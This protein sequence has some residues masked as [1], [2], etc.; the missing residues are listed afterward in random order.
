MGKYT[1][2][3]W[4]QFLDDAE[5]RR[6]SAHEEY[7]SYKND[8]IETMRAFESEYS[9]E[10]NEFYQF[11]REATSPYFFSEHYALLDEEKTKQV[12]SRCK[13][14]VLTANPI[15]KAIFHYMVVHQERMSRSEKTI[16]RIICKNTVFFIFKWGSYWVAHVHQAETG[17]NKNMGAN[18]TIYESLEY[19]RP[20]VIISL[21]VAFGID[22]RSQK[23][24]DVIVS[25]RVLPYS[26]NKRDEDKIK[27]D[28][29]QDKTIDNWLHMRLI[30][31]NGFLD[32][33]TYGDILS[34]GS[35]LS[36]FNEKDKIC[37]GYTKADY[38]IGGE[39]EGH[40]LFQFANTDGIPG[41]VIKGI[42]DWGVAKNDIFP[43]N[44]T[45]EERFKDSL[46][47]FAM[48]A[49]V[50]KSIPLFSDPKLF[51]EP[52]NANVKHL[53]KEQRV[54]RWCIGITALILFAMGLYKLIFHYT[55]VF[56]DWRF[57]AEDFG[58][59]LLILISYALLFV[60]GINT[61]LRWRSKHKE[62][63]TNRE[64]KTAVQHPDLT[65]VELSEELELERYL[66]N[67]NRE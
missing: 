5:K 40:A 57:N 58:S 29:S 41:V 20:N 35:V 39:M 23:I 50:E 54:Y 15:E 6:E 9:R 1:S 24:G 31:A 12:L 18:A 16:R 14:L 36:S 49:A 13:V 38:I 61:I 64:L 28:R 2:K 43:N 56:V 55:T 4:S 47:A 3:N 19:F 33:V 53:L 59:V 32:S 27:P 45:R 17:A 65:Q 62:Y 11:Y 60:L 46:Q 48:A 22:Y 34:G 30:N 10:L 66:Q 51:S 8:F 52:K 63:E 42:C 25:K 7:R 21:G 44:P 26:E 67:Q 37:L